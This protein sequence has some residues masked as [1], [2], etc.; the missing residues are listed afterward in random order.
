[1]PVSTNAF[2]LIRHAGKENLARLH[3]TPTHLADEEPG[4]VGDL[5]GPEEVHLL[6]AIKE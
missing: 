2:R 6:C 5:P 3:A 4:A 1:M